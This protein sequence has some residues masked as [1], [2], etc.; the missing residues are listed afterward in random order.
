MYSLTEARELATN[1]P[2]VF[3]DRYS[4]T[5]RG[6][7]RVWFWC[8]AEQHIGRHG[9]TVLCSLC[10]S[11]TVIFGKRAVPVEALAQA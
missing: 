3:R 6:D 2:G 7:D 11:E 10:G 1:N 5:K 4:M 9:D 8:C